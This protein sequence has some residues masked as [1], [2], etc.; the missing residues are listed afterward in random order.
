MT[1]QG[2]FEAE[3]PLEFLTHRVAIMTLYRRRI[4]AL[5][6]HVNSVHLEDVSGDQGLL[7]SRVAMSSR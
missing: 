1:Q 4:R 3:A 5:S 6:R 2:Y 7:S